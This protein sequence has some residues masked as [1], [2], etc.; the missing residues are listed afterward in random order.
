LNARD[1]NLTV[2]NDLHGQDELCDQDLSGTAAACALT[3][4]QAAVWAVLTDTSGIGD[5]FTFKV[6]A[7]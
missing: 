1:I 5:A 2:S 6:T 4:T 7:K 3:V